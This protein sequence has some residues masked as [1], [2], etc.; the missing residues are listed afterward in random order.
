MLRWSIWPNVSPTFTS[1]ILLP[2]WRGQQ[3]R[4]IGGAQIME[5]PE[6]YPRERL[7]ALDDFVTH[8]INWDDKVDNIRSIADELG[9]APETFLFIDDNP[10]ER[11]RVRQRLPEVEVWGEDLLDL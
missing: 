4:R 11:E 5:Y 6:S 9:F 8:R 3:E 10:V 7:L 2:R 1:S